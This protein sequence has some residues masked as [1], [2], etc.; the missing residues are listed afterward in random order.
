MSVV[1]VVVVHGLWFTFH[2]FIL[3]YFF[4]FHKPYDA[5]LG[6]VALQKVGIRGA[7]FTFL[8]TSSSPILSFPCECQVDGKNS[9]SW[10]HVAFKE[11]IVKIF[12]I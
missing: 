7:L 1:V 3:F 2:F 4:F 10:V 9:N 6:K 8:F 12:S 5:S 11:G